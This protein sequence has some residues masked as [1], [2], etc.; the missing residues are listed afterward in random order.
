MRTR[1]RVTS[2]AL[3]AAALMAS[4]V[5]SGTASAAA[6]VVGHVYVNNN[7]PPADRSARSTATRMG[8]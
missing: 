2:V 4:A 1:T 6:R 7:S 5:A 3:L 8:R